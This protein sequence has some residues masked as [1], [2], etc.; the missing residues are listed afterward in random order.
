MMKTKVLDMLEGPSEWCHDLIAEYPKRDVV[1]YPGP[2]NGNF[3]VF[4]GGNWSND[5]RHYGRKRDGHAPDYRSPNFGLRLVANHPMP[6]INQKIGN[7]F[8]LIQ[9]GSFMRGNH[10]VTISRPFYIDQKKV[11]KQLWWFVMGSMPFN[12]DESDENA[13]M[14]SVSWFDCQ[15]FMRNLCG[16]WQV[17]VG[18]FR[19]PTEAEWEYVYNLNS[20]TVEAPA[21][22]VE[23][24]AVKK[25]T[26]EE[27]LS[28]VQTIQMKVDIDCY[29][30]CDLVCNL[31]DPVKLA[32]Y[33]KTINWINI[34]KKSEV[35]KLISFL[36]YITHHMQY[37]GFSTLNNQ[38]YEELN[39][40][41]R[42]LSK[43]TGK[44][45]KFHTDPHE[46]S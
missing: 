40:W 26:L 21:V 27:S 14:H 3:C 35:Y 20:L 30:F 5:G 12:Y 11:T 6:A 44:Y 9:P 19:F 8:I 18:T 37:H 25:E 2:P 17:P 45:I 43:T 42:F 39:D 33:Q 34:E 22:K 31:S 13:P 28:K 41:V 36:Q 38:Q 1:D 7:N 24:P 32:L 46:C 15:K 10:R 23:A 16:Y 4:R 29:R